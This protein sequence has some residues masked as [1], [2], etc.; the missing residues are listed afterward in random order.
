ME[1]LEIW[2][3]KYFLYI[4]TLPVAQHES[5]LSSYAI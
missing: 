1:I 2:G 3:P 5:Q 4:L